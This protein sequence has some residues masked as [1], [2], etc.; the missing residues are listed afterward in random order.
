[1]TALPTWNLMGMM[2]NPWFRVK[3]SKVAG[4]DNEIWFEHPTR[5]EPTPGTFY[6]NGEYMHL[7]NGEVASPGWA[8]RLHK[9]YSAA[10]APKEK[11]DETPDKGG[12][13]AEV[14]QRLGRIMAAEAAEEKEEEVVEFNKD[15]RPVTL[16]PG[17]KMKL[18]LAERTQLSRTVVLYSFALPSAEHVLGL[19]VGQHVHISTKMA[20][21]RISTNT[22]KGRVDL[23]IK[24]YYKDEHPRFPDGGWLSQYMD[25]MKIGD[26]LD[27]KGP[28]GKIIYEGA[29]VFNIRGEK[30][31][32]EK[33]GCISGGTGVTPCFQLMQH[34]DLYK[35]P[36]EISL[37]YA[38]QTP[39]DI[40]LKDRLD[41]LNE[42]GMK[43]AYTV[44]R[45]P[46][47]VVWGGYVGFITADMVESTMPP[48]GSSTII[49]AC[50]PPIMVD[51]CVRPIC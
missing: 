8:E 3:V 4:N 18:K 21:P 34:A 28:T 42:K 23:V 32:Y 27:F 6:P 11:T 36:L 49:L 13:E 45:V 12:W 9:D 25:A 1:M 47:D 40:L 31:K 30:K 14:A 50:G 16:R 19:P 2:N 7:V 20:Y 29:G 35:E 46:N 39:D 51:K 10:Y 41:D 48:P 44:D 26:E 24:T 22:H 38:N 15:G 17:K 5:V 43:V 33:I 37:L